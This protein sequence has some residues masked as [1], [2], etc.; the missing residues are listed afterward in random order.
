M[1]ALFLSTDE[2]P[3]PAHFAFFV[4]N[5]TWTVVQASGGP[6]FLFLFFP[7]ASYPLT[8]AKHIHA[9]LSFF[10]YQDWAANMKR[11][12]RLSSFWPMIPK[13]IRLSGPLF[14][15]SLDPTSVK[16]MIF[17]PSEL[18]TRLHIDSYVLHLFHSSVFPPPSSFPPPVFPRR[19]FKGPADRGPT[20]SS[21]LFP[22]F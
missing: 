11:S 2:R 21:F 12:R 15:W 10:P 19:R 16:L 14:P 9:V 7:Q 18:V 6:P 8:A 13:V 3:Y 17:I 1:T 5:E 20:F 22:G 4:W